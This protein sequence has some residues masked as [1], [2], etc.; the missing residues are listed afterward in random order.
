DLLSLFW[1]RLILYCSSNKACLSAFIEELAI[2]PAILLQI[3]ITKPSSKI[4]TI[5]P[6]QAFVFMV[7]P[8]P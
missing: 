8:N 7:N 3:I 6:R 2:S 4:K 5:L 1:N